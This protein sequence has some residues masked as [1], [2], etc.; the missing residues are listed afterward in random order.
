MS[1]FRGAPRPRARCR[2]TSTRRRRRSESG[3]AEKLTVLMSASPA[4][5]AARESRP[6]ADARSCPGTSSSTPTAAVC[7]RPARG[8][9]WRAV[10][11]RPARTAPRSTTA[12][13]DTPQDHPGAQARIDFSRPPMPTTTAL[14]PASTMSMKIT[15]TSATE[16]LIVHAFTPSRAKT[17]LPPPCSPSPEQRRRQPDECEQ[18]P[19]PSSR[20][21]ARY[22]FPG[23]AAQAMS[24]RATAARMRPAASTGNSSGRRQHGKRGDETPRPQR[25]SAAPSA[26]G[27]APAGHAVGAMLRRRSV[28]RASRISLSV[29][30]RLP[31]HVASPVNNAMIVSFCERAVFLH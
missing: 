30:A 8:R 6:R 31:Q 5:K 14:S 28:E 20:R 15:C 25:Q 19:Q 2:A 13:A 9:R 24:A 29:P 23:G 1:P 4:P 12:A 10:A 3:A 17:A 18:A 16:L 27:D 26:Q 21:R 7:H 22:R 11:W